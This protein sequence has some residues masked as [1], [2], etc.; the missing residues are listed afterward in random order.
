MLHCHMTSLV[1]HDIPISDPHI[2]NV[3][4]LTGGFPLQNDQRGATSFLNYKLTDTALV[5]ANSKLVY[6]ALEMETSTFI[7]HIN[8]LALQQGN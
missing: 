4:M 1:T 5:I 2:P 3:S 7:A 8:L 6:V